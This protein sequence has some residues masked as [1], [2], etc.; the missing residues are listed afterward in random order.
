MPF[1]IR[2]LSTVKAIQSHLKDLVE[3]CRPRG[4]FYQH[5]KEITNAVVREAKGLQTSLDRLQRA[6]DDPNHKPS[7]PVP[8]T[9]EALGF[10]LY[11]E[12]H[13][14][15]LARFI[16]YAGKRPDQV[17]ACM[18]KHRDKHGDKAM[19]A[20]HELTAMDKDTNMTVL[21]PEANRACRVLLGP[22]PGSEEYS[23]HW[24]KMGCEPPAEHQPPPPEPAEPEAPKKPRKSRAR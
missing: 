15:E 20:V 14:Y 16:S 7:Q 11:Q 17:K 24:R 21:R 19:W 13:L 4:K 22:A 1:D 18:A 6:V 5:D 10:R 8:S 3:A 23:E 2:D 9:K 12:P